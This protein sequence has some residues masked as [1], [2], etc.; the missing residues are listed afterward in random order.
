[1]KKIILFL[2]LE[3]LFSGCLTV[4]RIQKNC[5]KF[6]KICTVNQIEIVYRDTTIYRTDTIRVPL[7]KDTVKIT[8]T[9]QVINNVA[10]LPPVHKQIGIIGVDASVEWSLLN[11]NAYLTDSTLLHTH[12]D[13]IVLEKVI[14]EQSETKIVKQK[15]TPRFYKIWFW[16]GLIAIILLVWPYFKV[17]FL[18]K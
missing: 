3:A 16:I 10:W 6:A 13:T 17:I 5:D 2:F 11:I 8:D 4:N 15:Y 14:K 9:I 12:K 7:P 1:M 18:R